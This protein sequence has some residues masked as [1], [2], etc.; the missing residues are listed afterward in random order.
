M[1]DNPI[2]AEIKRDIISSL[3]KGAKLNELNIMDLWIKN[4]E[5]K[6][7]ALQIKNETHYIKLSV[8]SEAYIS[9]MSFEQL[10][11]Y[12]SD[13]V[14]QPIK[15]I[16]FF[17]RKRSNDIDNLINIQLVYHRF[18]TKKKPTD[19]DMDERY[20]NYESQ[21][22]IRKIGKLS[23][24]EYNELYRYVNLYDIDQA[25]TVN[26]NL[27]NLSEE[28]RNIISILSNDVLATKDCQIKFCKLVYDG[29]KAADAL[30][31]LVKS[32]FNNQ[33]DDEYFK[34]LKKVREDV[35][36]TNDP[37]SVLA[38]IEL[39][40]DTRYSN[41]IIQTNDVNVENE[42]FFRY[43][44]ANVTSP[45]A[46]KRSIII[47]PTAMFIKKILQNISY[48][49][50]NDFTFVFGNEY[51]KGLVEHYFK[52]PNYSGITKTNHEFIT[53]ND[54]L[55]RISKEEYES[56]V[57]FL[58]N[59]FEE[60]VAEGVLK[61]LS[62]YVDRNRDILVLSP[63][64]VVIDLSE[65]SSEI[66][67]LFMKEILVIP[68]G[69]YKSK[70][71]KLAICRLN[72]DKELKSHKTK[73]ATS[74]LFNKKNTAQQ[75]AVLKKARLFNP[76]DI[77]DEGSIRNILD[78]ADKSKN[79]M[80]SSKRLLDFSSEIQLQFSASKS[81]NGDKLRVQAYIHEPVI[82]Y[83]GIKMVLDKGKCLE[84]SRKAARIE[85]ERLE[86][87]LLYEYPFSEKNNI[88][89]RDVI[90]EAYTESYAEVAGHF[91][92]SISLRTFWYISE[93]IGMDISSADSELL[94]DMAMTRLG[95]IDISETS[96]EDYEQLLED[97]YP[98]DTDKVRLNRLNILSL[99][100]ESAVEKRYIRKNV[101]DE[102]LAS[103]TKDNRID[104][105]RRNL[106][107][108]NFTISEFIEIENKI[109]EHIENGEREYIA[110]LIKLYT[111]IETNIVPALVWGD[112]V[113]NREYDFFQ[114]QLYRQTQNNG[115]VYR[116]I[117][118]QNKIRLMPCNGH[119]AEILNH[120]LE[121]AKKDY[122]DDYLKRHIVPIYEKEDYSTC[123][124]P[125]RIAKMSAELLKEVGIKEDI[126]IVPDNDGGT[127][128]TNLNRY[129]GDIFRTNMEYY[130][131]E[132]ASMNE[133][134][135]SYLLGNRPVTVI[136]TNY[137]DLVNDAL[138][139]IMYVKSQRIYALLHRNRAENI[140]TIVSDGKERK[141]RLS[142][143]QLVTCRFYMSSDKK[144]DA[145]VIIVSKHGIRYS[146]AQREKR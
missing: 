89:I 10:V 1:F 90:S 77:K 29:K 53:L 18:R 63:E 33:N 26:G 105:I 110:L 116:Q 118:N 22:E 102:A 55:H 128:E 111:G 52:N 24:K 99:L 114:L 92:V 96:M 137:V 65:G 83:D 60:K 133:D 143:E 67:W 117:K 88:K 101:I 145:E 16:N 103:D 79:S 131:R 23:R 97:I 85:P 20:K 32:Q 4:R 134:E 69:V 124:P 74:F 15:V 138:Q 130:F 14:A 82:R 11:L 126:I 9:D 13:V 17:K 80:R 12:S 41:D 87:W 86:E 25:W 107:K 73:L 51:S 93:E 142:N 106:V 2:I 56:D 95:E 64:N 49:S 113:E 120:L 78:K 6:P 136:G 144:R 21:A 100:L 109:N 54:F 62:E 28:L 36:R 19:A 104:L 42:I 139:Y 38:A 27:F 47:G 37:L 43:F 50:G 98:E 94:H 129:C 108:K 75:V 115:K 59:E 66:P 39:G 7:A 146:I 58:A 70:T 125:Y 35:L 30:D 72:S 84:N 76:S 61:R 112:F 81:E 45:L 132:M 46:S 5:G 3:P 57:Y 135:I 68:T 71:H 122:P 31:E 44:L 140:C 34:A 40:K 119:L 8:N 91:G 141:Y 127:I 121:Q 123:F 48:L